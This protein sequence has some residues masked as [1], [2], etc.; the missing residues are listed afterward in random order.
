[1]DI[2]DRRRADEEL[3]RQREE[4]A[5]ALRLTTLG[6]MA[7]S[8]SHEMNQPLT[9]I[10]SSAQAA[11][12]VLDT[13]EPDR[14]EI[15]RSA[16]QYIIEDS[17]RAAQVIR[18]L[19]ALFRKEHAERKPIDLNEVI[20]DV[21]ALVRGDAAR[22]GV[23]LRCELADG[24]P[25]V[26]ADIIQLQQVVLN[27][28]VNAMEATTSA[29][30]PRD[31]TLTTQRA[32]PGLLRLSVHDTGAGVEASELDKIFEPFVTTKSDGLGMGLSISRSIVQAHGGRI[33]AARNPEHGLT[34]HVELPC[35]ERP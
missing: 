29:E 4:L 30:E 20:M 21:V 18:R 33:W 28:I 16:I 19:R 11:R 2:T 15:V 32:E 12:R 35:E 25:A 1:V 24:L 8:L 26:S 7:A 31:V 3:R 22:R 14:G 9:A 5:H 23:S 13:A 17:K 34:V 27:L 6:E 10:L